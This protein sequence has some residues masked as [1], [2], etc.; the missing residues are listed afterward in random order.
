MASPSAYEVELLT[1]QFTA[2]LDLILQQTDKRLA[3]SVMTG[4]H[5]GKQASPVQYVGTL[6]FMQPAG[7]GQPLTPQIAQ[8][9]RRW[10]FPNDKDL[11][12]QVDEFDELRTIVDPRSALTMNIEAAGN[13]VFDD[14]LIAAALGTAQTGV[15]SSSLT[16]EAWNSTNSGSGGMNDTTG[17]IVANTFGAGSTSI[18]LTYKKL[19]E[20]RRI[21][22]HNEVDFDAEDMHLVV[23]SQQMSD[24]RNQAE[25]TSTEFKPGDMV[26]ENGRI[27]QVLGFKIRTSERLQYGS[28][29]RKC[30]AYSRR[31]LYLGIWKNPQVIISQRNDLSG[32]PWQAYA[33]MSAGATRL[34]KGL[35][36][37]I[38]CADTTTTPVNN[39]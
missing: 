31:G 20:A 28:S 8:Y 16:S 23:G 10:V 7:R 12:V 17:L 22:E 32:H 21:F 35:L 33:M 9:M 26:V 38:D 2:A 27:T 34:Q 1:T 30:L 13:R 11:A 39:Q 6:N 5:V 14:F 15:D 19:V 18:G 3:G 37:E 4:A 29:V 25:L 24:L 36:V